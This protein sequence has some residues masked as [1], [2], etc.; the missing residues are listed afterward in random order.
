MGK[1]KRFFKHKFVIVSMCLI[2]AGALAL[3]IMAFIPKAKTYTN[4]DTVEYEHMG[5]KVIYRLTFEDDKNYY[6][7]Y[8]NEKGKVVQ[9]KA[10]T[11]TY[12]IKDG[13]LYSALG[14][15][16]TISVYGIDVK[17]GGVLDAGYECKP[18]KYAMFAS[19]ALIAIGGLM[20]VLA[21]YVG[22]TKKKTNVAAA[23][24]PT[25]TSYLK[26]NVNANPNPATHNSH[27]RKLPP[28]ARKLRPRTQLPVSNISSAE[29]VQ[30]EAQSV[31]TIQ[32]IQNIE[33]TQPETYST[34]VT[35]QEEY[36]AEPI[37]IVTQTTE[38]N[39]YFDV[40]NNQ[41]AN[42]NIVPDDEFVELAKP[43]KESVDDAYDDLVNA[44]EQELEIAESNQNPKRN[45]Y[46][47][48]EFDPLEADPLDKKDTEN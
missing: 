20:F 14:K 31:E 6:I 25:K 43:I 36:N 34:E 26:N 13:V 47:E 18:A 38:Q 27:A 30:P 16:G 46:L 41:L 8:V 29:P 3:T 21:A 17:F 28:N 23:P 35:Q 5:E 4:K 11:G 9:E 2:L 42:E 33:P 7:D 24:S 37:E 39:D 15:W 1:L 10:I 32:F 12:E 40:I 48:E 45:A 22:I 19:I 44:I